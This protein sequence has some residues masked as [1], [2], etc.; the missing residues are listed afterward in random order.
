MQR[1]DYGADF[2]VIAGLL[3]KSCEFLLGKCCYAFFI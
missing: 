1:G 2:S 3:R